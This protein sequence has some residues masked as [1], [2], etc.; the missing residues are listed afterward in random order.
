[1]PFIFHWPARIKNGIASDEDVNAMDL[2]PTL[3]AVI[4]Q[5]LPTDRVHDGVSLLPM[6]DGKPLARDKD[7]PFYYYNCENLQA[8]RVGD[9]KLHLPRTREQLP[10]WDKNKAFTEITDPVLYNLRQDIAESQDV[11]P[12]QPETTRRMLDLARK[13]RE[14]LGEYMQRG[15]GQR[16]TGSVIPN[17]P[18]I[19]H[20]KDWGSVDAAMRATLQNERMQRRSRAGTTIQRKKP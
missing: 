19:S 12:R 17:A 3:S 14:E 10:F 18:V 15:T 6:F 20:E 11:A 2:F 9:W 16:A 1:V 13:A 7:A 8:I 5:P 4:N